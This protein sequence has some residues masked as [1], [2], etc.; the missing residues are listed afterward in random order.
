MLAGALVQS[1]AW[2]FVPIKQPL[3]ANQDSTVGELK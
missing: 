2:P 3:H 1:E